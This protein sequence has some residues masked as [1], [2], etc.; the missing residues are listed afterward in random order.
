MFLNNRKHA[1]LHCM[2]GAHRE[3]FIGSHLE[4]QACTRNGLMVVWEH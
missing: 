4:T 1:V 3:G 2:E